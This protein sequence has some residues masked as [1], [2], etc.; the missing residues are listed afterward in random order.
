M[1]GL[2][3]LAAPRVVLHDLG[4]IQEGS[5]VNALLVAVPPLVSV[6]VAVVARV[7]NAFVTVLAIGACY[8]AFLAIG[9]QLLWHLAFAEDPPRLGGNLADLS[10]AAQAVIFRAFGVVSS[11]LTDTAVG[12]I[13]GLIAGGIGLLTRRL[14]SG[15]RP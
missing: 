1:V 6:V 9:H 3:L 8:G 7:P 4:I 5:A 12:A 10:P 15:S 14:R 2:A 13:A 11:L